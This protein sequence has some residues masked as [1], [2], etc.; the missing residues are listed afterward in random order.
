M[1]PRT[2]LLATAAAV[3]ALLAAP[4]VTASPA[5][6]AHAAGAVVN[7]CG[8]NAPVVVTK[9]KRDGLYINWLPC[10]APMG[11]VTYATVDRYPFLVRVPGRLPLCMAPGQ[12]Y[13]PHNDNSAARR[14]VIT[15]VIR[16][17]S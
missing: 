17:N 15:P 14:T 11:S 12:L 13:Y 8:I 10:G 7:V 2:V 4:V 1:R 5:A 3:A 16:C 6:T 9:V